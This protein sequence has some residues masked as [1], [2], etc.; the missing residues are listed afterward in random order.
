MNNILSDNL[1]NLVKAGGGKIHTG[2]FGSQLHAADYVQEGIPCIMPANMKSNRVDLSDIAYITEGDANRLSKYIVKKDDIVYSRRG[3]VTLKALIR[4][5]EDGYFCGTGCLLLRPGDKFDSRF[6][7]HYLSTP[8]IQNWIVRQAVGATMPNLNTGILASIPFNGP[9]KEEQE[10]IADVLSVIE[11]KIELNNRINSELEAMAKTLYDYWFVQFDFP[12]ANGKPYKASGGKMVYNHT[13]KREI[14]VG[15]S[16]GTLD[17]LGQI[18]G[19]STPSTA[20]KNNF[21]EQGSAWIT[22]NDLSGNIGNKFISKG[23]MGVT[24]E[25]IK[26]ASLKKYPA[27]T[28]L[29]SSRAPIGYM[30]IA[31]NALTTNQGFKSFIPS[32]GYPTE[33]VYFTVKNSLKAIIQYASGSTFKEVSGTVIKTVKLALPPNELVEEFRAKV[34]DLFKRQDTLEQENEQLIALRDWLLPM[35][36]NGQVTVKP[37]TE[38]KEAQH[39]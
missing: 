35:L 4:E 5:K 38:S 19:G 2:P 26:S 24:A 27:G 21:S 28:V 18:V 34:E 25:G 13:L 12:D 9:K 23:A 37:S 11:D 29:L 20:D 22:P 10:K 17:N 36:M 30:A 3:D 31:R 14:P 15:W 1:G 33:F 16:D 39:G 32:K 7:T 8:T 6:L